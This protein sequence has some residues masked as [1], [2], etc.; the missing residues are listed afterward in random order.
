MRIQ[1]FGQLRSLFFLPVVAGL[2]MLA[3]VLALFGTTAWAQLGEPPIGIPV[4][5][6]APTAGTPDALPVAPPTST[7][8]ATVTLAAGDSITISVF[9]RPELTSTVYVSDGGTIDVPLAGSIPVFGLSPAVAA[10]RVATAYREG[11]YLIDPQVNVVLAG[12][13]SQQISI[14][15]EVARPGRF[16]IDTRTT[17][18]DALAQAGGVTPQGEER[19]FILR[20]REGG[21]DRFEVDLRDLF[22]LGTGQVVDLRAGDTVMVPK[23]A[24][25]YIYGE[26]A[27]PGSYAVRS[28]MTLIEAI[29]VAGGVTA[30]GSMRRIE[31]KRKDKDGKSR[32]V[33]ANIDDP[34]RGEDVINVRERIF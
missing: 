27:R 32:P 21:V 12:L 18:L 13:R 7:N 22:A 31:V 30:R 26:I 1:W 33:E 19:A 8:S 25:F 10:E 3:A 16:P 23:A 28:N 20:R 29:A 6:S 11:E 9:G 4:D 34:V 2:V 14:L 15:G 17:I 24:L 5:P